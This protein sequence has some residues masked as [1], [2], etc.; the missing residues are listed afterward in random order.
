MPDAVIF[1]LDGV[2]VDSEERWNAAREALT[3]ESG[4]T[5]TAEAP[6]AMMG[7]SAPEWS[8]YVREEL[9]VPMSAEDINAAV[10]ARMEAGYRD[11][12]P[13]LPGAVEAVRA[14]AA[15]W[16]LGLASSANRPIIGLV[17]EVA[18]LDACFG[19]TVSSEEVAHGKPAP[20]VYVEAARRL[21]VDPRRCV[22]IEAHSEHTAMIG[23]RMD[24]DVVSGL[25][26]G[27]EAIL[28]LSGVTGPNE[29]ERFPY[30]PSRI[31]DSIA[32]LVAEL[33]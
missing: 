14:L 5:W 32:D 23:D 11:G 3:R 6:R 12:L 10:V 19:A 28:V 7:M 21:G 9:G 15:R 20:D 16:P 33:G 2:L 22:A 18:G 4:G 27:L 29:A 17:L 1:D 13:L 24:T 30:R 25:E 31:V 8:R 26:A